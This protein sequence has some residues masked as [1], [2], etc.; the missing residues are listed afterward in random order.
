[1]NET[2]TLCNGIWL[3]LMKRG[4]WEYA[5]RTNPGGGVMIIAVTGEDKLLFVE[6]FRPALDCR[7]IEMPAGLVGDQAQARDE[8]AVAAAHRELV[9]ETGYAAGRIEYIMAGP[10]SA[11]MSNE[12]LAFVRAHD[13]K[14]IEAGGGDDTEDIVVH[15]I[16]RHEAARWLVER[17]AEGCSVDPKI[18][19]G[20]YFLDNEASMRGA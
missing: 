2:T 18:F 16:P 7:T 20:L 1:M 9:E 5:E 11:G 19:A 8:D 3:R 17:M 14:R 10:T 12:I 15:E 4:R 13:L 6:Q